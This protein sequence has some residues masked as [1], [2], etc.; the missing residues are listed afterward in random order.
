MVWL[1]RCDHRDEIRMLPQTRRARGHH[2]WVGGWMCGC[3]YGWVGCVAVWVGGWVGGCEYYEPS[4]H[5]I[6]FYGIY[7]TFSIPSLAPSLPPSL[8]PSHP[9]P[10]S[11]IS[12]VLLKKSVSF[13]KRFVLYRRDKRSKREVADYHFEKV[14]LPRFA[15]PSVASHTDILLLLLFVCL[16]FRYFEAFKECVSIG[17]YK[18]EL[19]C[20]AVNFRR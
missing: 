13:W 2:G 16:F 7:F 4:L 12:R 8:P 14:A 20:V 3:M 10:S 18:K 6:L 19:G 9:F 15:Q 5:P 1:H 17:R 11:Y